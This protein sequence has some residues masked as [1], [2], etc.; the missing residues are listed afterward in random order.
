ME[1]GIILYQSK[2][3][4]TK[5]Y[6][7]WLSKATGYICVET[8]KTKVK[9][10]LE[11]DVIVLGGGV[12]AS[13]IAG[14]NFLKKNIQALSGKKIAVFAVGA[15]PYNEKAIS[16]VRER[17]FVNGLETIPLFYCRGAWD[18]EKM[19]FAHRTL[20][21]MLQKAVAKKNTAEY[22]PWESA[23]MGAKGQRCD[24]TEQSYLD[25]ILNYLQN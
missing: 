9:D 17:H 4:S 24:W 18:E 16:Q 25:P 7:E 1:K 14:I 5:K 23:L 3:G 21:K 6:A 10:I 13:G 2:Y 11:Y 22:E 12:Y 19:T 20:C 15:S 8:S